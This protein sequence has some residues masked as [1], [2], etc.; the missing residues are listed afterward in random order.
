MQSGNVRRVLAKELAVQLGDR[1]KLPLRTQRAGTGRILLRAKRIRQV[2]KR[3]A[4][5]DVE[6][7]A[8]S[9]EPVGGWCLKSNKRAR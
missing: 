9:Y 7:R 3:L 5:Y 4:A 2:E 6:Q 1:G 8:M